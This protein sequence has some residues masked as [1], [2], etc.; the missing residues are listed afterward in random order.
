MRAVLRSTAFGSL[1]LLAAS[2]FAA[3]CAHG[4]T[5]DDDVMLEG[6]AL[7]TDAQIASRVVV[8][9][10]QAAAAAVVTEDTIRIPMAAASRVGSLVP[11]SI[12]VSARGPSG[13]KNP[14]G[15]LRTV[16]SAAEEK[17]VLVVKTDK[18]SITDAIVRGELRTGPF[19]VRI[20]DHDGTDSAPS[21]GKTNIPAIELALDD[22]LLFENTDEIEGANG[23]VRFKET[24]RIDRG[25]VSAQPDVDVDLRIRDG[26]V[27]RFSAKVEGSLDAE[28][29][30]TARVEADGQVDDA[31][32]AELRAKKHHVRKVL[33]TTRRI[34]LPTL[35]VGKVP[36]SPSVQ[37]TVALVCDLSF[38]GAH[39]ARAG[40]QARS[41][42][43]LTATYENGAWA[44]PQASAFAIRP[45]FQVAQP[46]EVDAK[47]ALESSA[48]LSAYGVGG[49]TMSV[50][51]WVSYDVQ[52]EG[53]TWTYRAEAGATGAMRGSADVFG[54]K[55][56]D[57]E[58][59]LVDWSAGAP[60][61]G[62]L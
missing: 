14:D 36:V 53:S 51:P 5:A 17:G 39:V 27:S 34:P 37:V 12:F 38:G 41:S 10:A 29:L 31:V 46:G 49:V 9:D 50:A 45:T 11:G 62:R 61:E 43:K 24:I 7:T 60:V 26:K 4:S 54:V 44:P 21:V 40:V 52:R 47:C 56:E 33:H 8:A 35:S 55:P 42:V 28:M 30:A 13:S 16:V 23:P 32:L 20:D 19:G 3:G 15:F 57:L 1:F 22:Q 48:E 6:S 59:T 2:G 58:R 18:A 25:K